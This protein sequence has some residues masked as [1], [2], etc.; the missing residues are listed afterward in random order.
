ML[1]STDP[2]GLVFVEHRNILPVMATIRSEPYNK[3]NETRSAFVPSF[4]LVSA[5]QF[6]FG[7]H[8]TTNQ[9][10]KNRTARTVQSVRN[11]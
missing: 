2:A 6:R 11:V 9:R 3:R 10:V 7:L 5:V 1:S 8:G 4:F